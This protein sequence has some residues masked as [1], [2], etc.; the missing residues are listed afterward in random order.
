M[1][2][3]ICTAIL[4]HIYNLSLT[5]QRTISLPWVC[6]QAKREKAEH[7]GTA[8]YNT[9]YNDEL[10]QVSMRFHLLPKLTVD[11]RLYCLNACAQPKPLLIILLQR[12]FS[13]E[14]TFLVLKAACA[15]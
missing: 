1:C 2:S 9:A 14:I 4:I 13:M 12:D 7:C 8:L 5:S 3:D 6:A 15:A 11:R 10:F